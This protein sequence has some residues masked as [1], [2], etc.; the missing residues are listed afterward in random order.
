MKRAL[1]IFS[2]CLLTFSLAF[3]Q[4]QPGQTQ[5][6]RSKTKIIHAPTTCPNDPVLMSDGTI[7]G[8]DS[9]FPPPSTNYYALNAKGGH[10]Y[11][12]E[13][14]DVSDATV[15]MSPTITVTSD[16]KNSISG[17]A[18]VTSA[19]PDLSNG[20]SRRVSW[21]QPSDQILYLAIASTDPNENDSYIY[22]IRVTDTS[23]HNIHWS[24]FSYNTLWSLAN[25][26]SG[27][28]MGT[29]TVNNEQG[30]TV[31][32]FPLTVSANGF[33]QVNAKVVGIPANQQGA[34]TFVYVGPAAAIRGD[35]SLI[36]NDSNVVVLE[37][38]V[39]QH[40]SY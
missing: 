18:D 35:V 10:S 8:Y 4:V 6:I 23:L 26:T 1:L 11:S 39:P 7:N 9:L 12:I 30:V 31:G 24:T 16:C 25:L 34:A 22:Y 15:G 38:F 20:F 19:D 32:T 3:S 17:V 29:L 21:V 28:I 33:A 2:Y 5:P 36:R 27:D 13:V 40:S 14:W 37:F